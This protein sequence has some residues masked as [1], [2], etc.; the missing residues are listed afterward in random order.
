MKELF[1][2]IKPSITPWVMS[3]FHTEHGLPEEF[4]QEIEINSLV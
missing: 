3:A 1:W 4:L 2:I